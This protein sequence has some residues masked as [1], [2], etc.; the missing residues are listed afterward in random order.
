LQ[1]GPVTARV[2][3]STESDVRQAANVLADT[4]K[5]DPNN[6]VVVGA[7][8]DSVLPGAGHQ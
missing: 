2:E 8:L 4:K 3:T 1:S 6:V 5:G 7:H